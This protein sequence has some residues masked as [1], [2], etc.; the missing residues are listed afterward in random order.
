MTSSLD[1]ESPQATAN[2]FLY[3]HSVA[4]AFTSPYCMFSDNIVKI[5]V[6]CSGLLRYRS[7][8]TILTVTSIKWKILIKLVY[9]KHVFCGISMKRTTHCM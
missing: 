7:S 1:S 5:G 2:L 4:K 8:W 3:A 6:H 9:Q